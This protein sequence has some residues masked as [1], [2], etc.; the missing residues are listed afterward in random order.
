MLARPISQYRRTV[1]TT[2]RAVIAAIITV[3]IGTSCT[4]PTAPNQ[5]K[6]QSARPTAVKPTA[7]EKC[8]WVNPWV[9]R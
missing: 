5:A 7:D 9:C 2:A 6:P 4:S 8:D 1:C 3:T